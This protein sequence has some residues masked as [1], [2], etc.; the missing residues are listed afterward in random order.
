MISNHA[1]SCKRLKRIGRSEEWPTA[2]FTCR[3]WAADTQVRI[4]LNRTFRRTR[5]DITHARL[6]ILR[7]RQLSLNR[8]VL[9]GGELAGEFCT[10][11]AIPVESFG[12]GAY[13]RPMWDGLAGQVGAYGICLRARNFATME[14]S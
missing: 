13:P 10:D 7:M 1:S 6:T 14:R 4:I 9:E 12:P 8:A 3:Q 5:R 2:G 11:V